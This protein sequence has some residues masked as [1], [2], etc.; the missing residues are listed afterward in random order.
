MVAENCG[1]QSCNATSVDQDSAP[2]VPA[3]LPV[4][5]Q[6]AHLPRYDVL[7]PSL[8]HHT[9]VLL[10]GLPT[11]LLSLC[12]LLQQLLSVL[13]IIPSLLEQRLGDGLCGGRHS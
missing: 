7:D 9:G 13:G 12:S 8:L 4:C 3:T 6:H 11:R 5:T 10:H 1:G 2:T